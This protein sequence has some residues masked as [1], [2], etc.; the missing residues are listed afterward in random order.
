M[1]NSPLGSHDLHWI[2]QKAPAERPLG[3]PGI[4]AMELKPST[5]PFPYV[6][7][8]NKGVILLMEEMPKQPPLGC[9]QPVNIRK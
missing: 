4:R 3:F 7:I 1:V 6:S 8:P 2:I 9:I 5:S